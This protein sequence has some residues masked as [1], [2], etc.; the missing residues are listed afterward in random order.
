MVH[1][2]PGHFLARPPPISLALCSI[3]R[4][5]PCWVFLLGPDNNLRG[6]YIYQALEPAAEIKDSFSNGCRWQV[7]N[8]V[9]YDIIIM[10]RKACE[11]FEFIEC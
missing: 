3:S 8:I 2:R 10:R 9:I 5:F 6:G 7:I 11:H 1:L 4:L